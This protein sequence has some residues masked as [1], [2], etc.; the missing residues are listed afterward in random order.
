MPIELNSEGFTISDQSGPE[1][2]Y[3][4]IALPGG[5]HAGVP[6]SYP[7]PGM[8]SKPISSGVATGDTQASRRFTDTFRDNHRHPTA[9]GGRF[10]QGR[11][12]T[13]EREIASMANKGQL[14]GFVTTDLMQGEYVVDEVGNNDRGATFASVWTAPWVPLARYFRFNYQR[15]TISFDYQRNLTDERRGYDDYFEAAAKFAPSVRIRVEYGK[16]PDYAITSVLGYPT[17]M[18]PVIEAAMAGDP[19]LLGFKDEPNPDLAKILG[20]NQRGMRVLSYEPEPV[21]TPQQVLA[22]PQNELLKMIAELQA[23]QSELRK[24]LAFEREKKAKDSARMEKVRAAR[25]P[26]SSPETPAA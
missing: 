16:I 18:V 4:G 8:P 23:Q 12:W 22:T 5:G 7:Q 2:N 24:E 26:R 14:P 1:Q 11:P 21:A 3:D 15:K 6:Q 25:K 20:Y 13:G 19:W 17:M 9:R 10:A